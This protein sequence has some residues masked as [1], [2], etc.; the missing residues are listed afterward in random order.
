MKLLKY[1]NKRQRLWDRIK[2]KTGANY[3]LSKRHTL[4]WK[5]QIYWKKKDRKIFYA[6]NKHKK[7]VVAITS[8]K[9]DIKT[10]TFLDFNSNIS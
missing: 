2:K 7:A 5:V 10:K 9:T 4:D 3:M 8:N 1:T 6:D